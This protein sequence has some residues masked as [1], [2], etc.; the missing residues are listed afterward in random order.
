MTTSD[1]KAAKRSGTGKK[2]RKLPGDSTAAEDLIAAW[3]FEGREEG[4]TA[5]ASGGGWNRRGQ[6]STALIVKV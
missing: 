5:T 2:E 4:T 1:R 6:L 3:I